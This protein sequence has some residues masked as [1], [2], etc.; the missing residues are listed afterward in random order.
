MTVTELMM[1]AKESYERPRTPRL[2]AETSVNDIECNTIESLMIAHDYVESIPDLHAFPCLRKLHISRSI[3]LSEFEQLD[4]SS[5]E[6][7]YVVFEKKEPIIK[8]NLPKLKKLEVYISNNEDTQLSLFDAFDAV[9]DIRGCSSLEELHLRH[10]TGCEIKTDALYTL[11]KFVCC[12]YKNYNFDLL[13]YTPNLVHL[14]A[15][16]CRLN[17]VDFLH[18]VPN[19]TF[20]DLTFNEITNAEIIFQLSNL[21]ALHIYRNPLEDIQKFKAL[22]FETFVTEKDR[23]FLM[24]VHSIGSS[25]FSAYSML[26]SARKQDPKRKPF[27]QQIYDRQTDEQI[28]ARYF[29]SGIKQN[30]EY[31][32]STEKNGRKNVLLSS[33]ELLEFVLQEYPFLSEFF[34]TKNEET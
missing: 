7:L 11:K 32:T 13:N 12:D 15:T 26:K 23:D 5:I 6:E 27:L 3:S 14:V 9:L 34:G 18:L 31:H 22:P 28:Y 30:I 17:K 8:I 10:C 29:A 33:D 19:L 20:L 24:F 25:Q 21:R 4:L 1:Q 16:S 2:C